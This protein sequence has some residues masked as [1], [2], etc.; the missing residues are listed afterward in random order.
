[1]EQDIVADR[2]RMKRY[3]DSIELDLRRILK[4]VPAFCQAMTLANILNGLYHL[5]LKRTDRNVYRSEP[6]RIEV[7]DV[8]DDH[9]MPLAG[10]LEQPLQD[11]NGA[12]VG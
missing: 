5:V 11:G 12:C 6:R 9:P 8:V 1:M 10:E 4:D 2:L 7:G 3:A